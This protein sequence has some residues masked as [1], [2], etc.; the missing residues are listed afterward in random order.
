MKYP[1]LHFREI[2]RTLKIPKTT[3]DYHLRI[4][5]KKELITSEHNGRYIRYFVKNNISEQDK[6]ILGMLRIDVPLKIIKYLFLNSDSSKNEI[7]DQL[8]CNQITM[9][10]YLDKLLKLD[11]VENT[12]NPNKEE[13]RIKNKKE[14]KNIFLKYQDF[15]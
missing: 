8:E 7:L 4:L 14:I 6:K 9:S 5:E 10:Y 15:F 3:L 12:D 11:L 1:G 13:F 2:S